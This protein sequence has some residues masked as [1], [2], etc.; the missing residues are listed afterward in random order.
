MNL[1]IEKK[2]FTSQDINWLTGSMWIIV[3]FLSAVWTLILTAPI[4]CRGST[5][6]RDVLLNFSKSVLMKNKLIYILADLKESTFSENFYFW[7]D[8]KFK[9]GL[10][11][12]INIKQTNILTIKKERK[13]SLFLCQFFVSECLLQYLH[14]KHSASLLHWDIPEGYTGHCLIL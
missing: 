1:F 5:G 13:N 6:E 12:L 8:F 10:I 11:D 7:V 9:C 14:E 3:T 2:L 4:H